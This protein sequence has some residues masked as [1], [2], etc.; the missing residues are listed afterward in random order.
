M[1]WSKA[2]DILLWPPN[3]HTDN[4]AYLCTYV[5]TLHTIHTTRATEIHHLRVLKAE[6]QNPRYQQ[7]HALSENCGRLLLAIFQPLVVCWLYSAF[8]ELQSHSSS[9]CRHCYMPHF[10]CLCFQ[11]HL[12]VGMLVI[13]DEGPFYAIQ[14]DC[15]LSNYISTTL[16]AI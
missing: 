15:N 8:P 3:A 6:V 12:F 1:R 7:G 4:C 13:L 5:Y 9:V 2:V 10:L 16:F 11:M 14:Y